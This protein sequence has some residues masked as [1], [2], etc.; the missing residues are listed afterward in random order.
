MKMQNHKRAHAGSSRALDAH[1]ATVE[2]GV[3][4]ALSGNARK[5]F[6]QLLRELAPVG[7]S[8]LA[9]ALVSLCSDGWAIRHEPTGR[10][11][12][13]GRGA[14]MLAAAARK[15]GGQAHRRAA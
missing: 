1:G 8:S 14:E 5:K 9:A 6:S 3:L 11:I 10:Y 4:L 7:Q 12:L 13:S 2:S 15:R